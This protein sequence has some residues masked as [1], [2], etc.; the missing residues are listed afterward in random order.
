[1]SIH[2]VAYDEASDIIA[3]V[4]AT[5][6]GTLNNVE[7]STEELVATQEKAN[8]SFSDSAIAMN[9][10]ALAGASLFMS[11]ERIQNSQVTL[12][13]ANLMVER[14]TLAVQKA[15]EAYNMAVEKY[16]PDSQQAKDAAD[17]LS[18]AQEALTVAQERVGIAQ[19]NNTNAMLYASLT[20]IPSLITMITAVGSAT[21]IWTGI[22]AALNAVMDAN[23]IFLVIG[24]IAALAVG[25]VYLYNTCKPVRDAINDIGNALKW[26][27]DLII[28]SVIGTVKLLYDAFS[29]IGNA[30]G[31]F[32]HWVSG[33]TDANAQLA[34]SAEDATDAVK[35]QADAVSTANNEMIKSTAD[36]SQT[37]S[38]SADSF[39]QAQDSIGAI[40]AKN[41]AIIKA[42]QEAQAKAAADNAK[43]LTNL[44]T[45]YGELGAAAD[46]DLGQIQAAFDAAFNKGDLATAAAIVQTFAD[47]YGISLTTA[48][49]DILNFKAAQAQIPLSIEDQLVGKAQADIKAFQDCTTGKMGALAEDSTIKM[50]GMA[51]DITDLI[52]HGLVGEAQ[53]AMQAYTSCSTD[54]VAT[55]ATDIN[56]QMT[57]LTTDHNAQIKQMSDLAASLTG[58]EKDAVLS[59]IDTMNTEYENKLT[60]LRDWQTMLF[61]QMKNNAS[62][63]LGD[64]GIMATPSAGLR[65]GM[66]IPDGAGRAS[67]VT[68]INNAPLVQI[69][70]SADKTTVDLASK[71]VLQALQTTIVEPTSS[72][73]GATQKRIRS[74]SVFI[75]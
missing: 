55:M 25:I 49:N 71:Q 60:Q 72:A 69:Q 21:Q 12:D 50:K 2:L 8:S 1:V 52:N 33:A 27:A 3:N 28:G 66:V 43:E 24:V 16:G 26:L 45:K 48:E 59:E 31:G 4:G 7:S 32:I 47:K 10:T 70:G 61:N 37:E 56:T 57:K 30:I 14:S 42:Q 41:Q 11:F 51:N 5:M 64:L 75:T 20:V 54:K 40:V 62:Q 18:I 65:G 6:Q 68:V 53:T 36:M 63:A 17:K 44:Q 19:R 29:T 39:Q 74:G 67:P 22:Q 23:P 58:D 9:S 38:K 15:Q 46:K 73:A 34:K 13:R 35:R